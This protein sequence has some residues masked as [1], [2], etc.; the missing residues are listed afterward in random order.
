MCGD[1]DREATNI[2]LSQGTEFERLLLRGWT[3]GA[4]WTA[5]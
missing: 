5:Q 2:V 4:P 1:V 3:I